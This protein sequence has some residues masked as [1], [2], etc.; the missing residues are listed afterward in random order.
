MATARSRT[1]KLTSRAT[2]VAR[3]RTK[4]LSS[5]AIRYYRVTNSMTLIPVQLHR[6]TDDWE[7]EPITPRP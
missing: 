7:L 3:S 2:T 5:P 1:K 6:V 4:Q